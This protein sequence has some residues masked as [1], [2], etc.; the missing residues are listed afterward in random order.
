MDKW[1]GTGQFHPDVAWKKIQQADA[2][3]EFERKHP[4]RW[5]HNAVFSTGALALAAL[6][7]ASL[8]L[9]GLGILSAIG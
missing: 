6:F 1:E 8:L 5:W 3:R 7:V 4:T 9:I 2:D